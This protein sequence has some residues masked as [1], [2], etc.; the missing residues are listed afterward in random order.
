MSSGESIGGRYLYVGL[1]AG[2]FPVGFGDGVDGASE[3]DADHEVVVDAMAIDW[4]RA[5]SSGF[6]D[7]GS[8]LTHVRLELPAA[9]IGGVLSALARLGADVHTPQLHG[10]LSVVA[11]TLPSAQ[12][13]GLQEQ[14]PGLTGGEGA[15][16]ASFGCYQ[17]VHGNTP[18]R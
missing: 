6:A 3:R 7:D 5:T 17:P 8:T 13:R 10:D 1:D 11:T 15:L 18:S 9:R 2:A 4:M 12:V 16:E 14:L